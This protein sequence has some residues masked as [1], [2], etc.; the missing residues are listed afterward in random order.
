MLEIDGF[1][2]D[3]G[4]RG[5]SLR[6]HGVSPRETEQIFF[7]NAL[8][9][10]WDVKHS[11][12]EMRHIAFGKT[13]AGRALAVAFTYRRRSEKTYLRPISARPMNKKERTFYEEALSKIQK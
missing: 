6:K 7:D 9:I 12:G 8:L 13:S 2:W 1:E 3:F 10:F 11:E 4:N 5:K